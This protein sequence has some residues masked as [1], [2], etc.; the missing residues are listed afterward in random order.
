MG[1]QTTTTAKTTKFALPTTN[2][3]KTTTSLFLQLLPQ[4]LINNHRHYFII[5]LTPTL[6]KTKCTSE[7]L[8]LCCQTETR[9]FSADSGRVLKVSATTEIKGQYG[10]S[11]SWQNGQET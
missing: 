1:Q 5:I 4:K 10:Q 7:W 3:Q 8:S 6:Y 9:N 11:Q 2:R